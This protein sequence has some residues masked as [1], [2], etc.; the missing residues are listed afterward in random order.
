[1]VR[2][3]VGRSLDEATRSLFSDQVSAVLGRRAVVIDLRDVRF[4]DRS[5]LRALYNA[6][7]RLH[8]FRTRVWL[9]CSPGPVFTYLRR[10]GMEWVAPM[11]VAPGAPSR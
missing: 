7:R 1:M 4:V 2:V 6:V 8:D 9:R 10:V 3:R 11:V 5:G